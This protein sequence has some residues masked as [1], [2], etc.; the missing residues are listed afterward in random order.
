MMTVKEIIHQ[1]VETGKGIGLY[2][3]S[4]ESLAGQMQRLTG[5]GVSEKQLI[6][7][8]KKEGIEPLDDDGRPWEE[9]TR[10]CAWF[11]MRFKRD[12]TTIGLFDFFDDALTDSEWLKT[13]IINAKANPDSRMRR[14]CRYVNEQREMVNIGTHD[15]DVEEYLQ[16][17]ATH[18]PSPKSTMAAMLLCRIDKRQYDRLTPDQ[19]Q[20]VRENPQMQ[21][22]GKVKNTL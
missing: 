2:P 12:E 9:S 22:V 10:Q 15:N 6:S 19:Q 3:L 20:F 8:L 7:L 16:W 13:I 18:T 5:E 1:Y 4:S 21:L 14:I 17:L 11:K